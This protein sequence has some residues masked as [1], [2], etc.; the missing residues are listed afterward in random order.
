MAVSIPAKKRGR[1][2][3]KPSDAELASKYQCMT[4]SE[5]AEEYHVKQS[6]VESWIYRARKEGAKLENGRT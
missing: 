4:A 3:K 5:I 1:P 2:S 6:T